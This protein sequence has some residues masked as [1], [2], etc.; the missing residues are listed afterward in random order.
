MHC[1]VLLRERGSL[2]GAIPSDPVSYSQLPHAIQESTVLIRDYSVAPDLEHHIFLSAWSSEFPSAHVIA[3]EGLAEKRANQSKTDKSVT[4]VP[5]S[6]IFTAKD[7]ASIKVGGE[8]DEEFEYEF[9]ETH[10]NKELVFFHKPSKTLIEADLLFNLPAREQYS[11]T[12]EDPTTGWATRIFG[13]LQNT[14]GDAIWQKRLL[15]YAMSKGNRLEFN[16]SMQRINIWG[17]ENIV[18]CH[19]ETLVGDGKSV[20]EKVMGWHLEGKKN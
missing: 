10:P 15:W 12:G 7:K 3:P 11:R 13:A 2:A 9:V 18:P 14:R 17:F 4:N 6:T 19:G 1:F 20:F 8:F 16:K 5:I